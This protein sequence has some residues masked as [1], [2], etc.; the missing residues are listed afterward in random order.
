MTDLRNSVFLL[1]IFLILVFGISNVR[2]FEANIINF[3]PAFFI[4]LTLAAFGGILITSRVSI[5]FYLLIWAVL[6]VLVWV[7]Y[8]RF[9]PEPRNIQ[10]IGVQFIL[11]EISAGLSYFVGR[12]VQQIDALVRGL[13]VRAYPNR[14]MDIKAGREAINT[15]VTRSRRYKRPFTTIVM[16]LESVELMDDSKSTDIQ[17]DL[18]RRF[19]LA[20]TGQIINEFARQTD[21]IF[22]DESDRFILLCPETDAQKSSILAER[23]SQSVRQSLGAKMDWGA[24]S[25][26][27]DALTFDDLVELSIRRMSPGGSKPI[28][29]KHDTDR[30]GVE[31]P[32]QDQRSDS[33]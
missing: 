4:L 24:A 15:E 5:Y 16:K 11:I 22:S 20:K 6:Y 27:N 31:M 29:P 14:T 25:F 10:V 13:S 1:I 7:F 28:V 33:L 17:R 2:S 32:V 21:M 19:A 18:L 26:P 9:L 8:F 23:I 3:Y 12:Q 30:D